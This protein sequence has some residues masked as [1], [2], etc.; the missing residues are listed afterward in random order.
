[1][2]KRKISILHILVFVG[3]LISTQIYADEPILI[4]GIV[5]D[6]LTNR[7][8]SFAH[9]YIPELNL[10]TA[11]NLQGEFKFELN[12]PDSLVVSAIGYEK[13]VIQLSDSID[14]RKLELNIRL[15]PKVYSLAEIEI[16][17]FP[18][19]EEFKR[20]ILEYEM[21]PEELA[22]DQLY[23]AFRKNLAMLSRRSNDLDHRESDGGISI[24]S[25]ITAMYNLFS[26]R[27][28]NEKK[29][30]QLLLADQTKLKVQE[31]LS[32]EVVSRLTGLKDKK[33]VDDF[34]AYCNFPDSLVLGSSDIQLYTLITQYFKAYSALD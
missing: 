17:P 19:Y 10:G 28:K 22:S 29:Y 11:S 14:K 1:M 16:R 30:R 6:Q 9:I 2:D 32:F 21:T 4:K 31:R 24:G 34:I 13:Q 18:T 5:K 3:V 7:P 20:A 25:P 33:E 23:K 15:I 8:I 12:V 27:A 26:R